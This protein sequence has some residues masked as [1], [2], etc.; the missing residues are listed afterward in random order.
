MEATGRGTG[1]EGIVEESVDAGA[2][3]AEIGLDSD[4]D[5]GKDMTGASSDCAGGRDSVVL[6]EAVAVVPRI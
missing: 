4:D 6:E 1:T 3:C 2:V 5:C